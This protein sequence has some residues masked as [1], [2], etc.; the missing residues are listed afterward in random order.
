M[1]KNGLLEEV[2]SLIPHSDKNALKT[3]GYTEMFEHLDGDVSLEQA[4]D[5]LKVNTRR[6]AK[7]QL[8]WFKRDPSYH[9][10]HPDER[11]KIQEL[12]T[13]K[14]NEYI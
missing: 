13:L 11:N 7:K 14:L 4:I 8:N 6:Y 10:F 12:I 1:I 5:N 9:W 3:V 2:K